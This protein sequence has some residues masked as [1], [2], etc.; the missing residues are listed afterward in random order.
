MSVIG[1]KS[2]SVAEYERMI[3]N[4]WLHMSVQACRCEC[5]MECLVYTC[6]SVKVCEHGYVRVSV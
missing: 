6:V 3:V 1:F 5:V 2:M 4:V